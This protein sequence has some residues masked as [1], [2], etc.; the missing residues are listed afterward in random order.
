MKKSQ[1]IRISIVGVVILT[2]II[3]LLIL[4]KHTHSFG[5]WERFKE[6][7]CAEFGIDRRFCKCGE[8]QEKKLDKLPHNESNWIFDGEHNIKKTVC[9]VCS[10]VI[11]SESLDGHSHNWGNWILE[12]EATCTEQGINSRSC[13]CGAKDSIYISALGHVFDE[14]IILIEAKCE[15]DGTKEH[16][17]SVCNLTETQT[18][19]ALTHTEGAWI[20]VDNNK[21]FPCI[22]CGI[23]LRT[24]E[25]H[26]SQ[27]LEI[28]YGAVLS[29]GNC[30]DNNIVI[31]SNHDNTEVYLIGD[32]SFEYENIISIVIPNTVTDIKSNA[33]YQCAK[34]ETVILGESV[35]NIDN[36]A[37]FKCTALNS[38]VLPDSLKYLGAYTFAYCSNLK[39]IHIGSSIIELESRTFYDCKNLTSIYFNGTIDEWNSI[40]K[41]IEWDLGTPDYVIYCTDGNINK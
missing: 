38:I 39:S 10:R 23:N 35:A 9:T 11:K 8:I 27:D 20:I 4:T 24:E 22:Y 21:H 6:S 19:T 5:E 12:K 36:K 7:S 37:F 25:I 30:S 29:I 14:W 31:P 15:V 26:I 1:I 34:L 17:C 2:A 18:I 13:E 40:P 32:Q 41:N 33:F 28:V 16:T 3:I